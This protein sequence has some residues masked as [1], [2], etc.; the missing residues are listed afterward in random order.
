[1]YIT[2]SISEDLLSR[3]QTSGSLHGTWLVLDRGS[4]TD[5]NR[6][7]GK[8]VYN[9][10]LQIKGNGKLAGDKEALKGTVFYSI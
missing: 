6:L 3:T 5:I 10:S 8:M 2:V 4:A 7:C 9:M 1:L